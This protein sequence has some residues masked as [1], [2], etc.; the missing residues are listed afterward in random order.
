[1]EKIYTV[2]E[3]L[4]EIK[5]LLTQYFSKSLWVQAELSNFHS[6]VSGHFYFTLKDDSHSLKCAMFKNANQYLKFIPKDG[7][8]VLAYGRVTIYEARG[9]CQLVVESL[10]PS[11]QGA[12]QLAYE[13]LKEK[14]LVEG[15]FE[16]SRK[17]LSFG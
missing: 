3:I 15:L 4:R 13:Q 11:G 12:L 16:Q 8:K 5:G 2:C 10:E 6:S 1:M 14:L 9:D 17:N 7:Q